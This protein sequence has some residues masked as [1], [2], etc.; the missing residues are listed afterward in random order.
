MAKVPR[1]CG[2]VL[3]GKILGC[4]K[5]ERLFLEKM[6]ICDKKYLACE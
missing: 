5:K 4:R 1:D 3:Y 2:T 6:S